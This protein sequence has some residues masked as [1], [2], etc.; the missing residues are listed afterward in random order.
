M[1]DFDGIE[2]LMEDEM[3]RCLTTAYDAPKI[4]RWS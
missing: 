3:R 4:H 1:I 2:K